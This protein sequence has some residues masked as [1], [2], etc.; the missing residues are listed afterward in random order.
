[1]TSFTTS[2]VRALVAD[3]RSEKGRDPPQQHFE[4]KEENFGEGQTM[5][6]STELPHSA[7]RMASNFTVIFDNFFVCMCACEFLLSRFFHSSP[8]PPR[9]SPPPR[10]GPPAALEFLGS[11]TPFRPTPLPP[12]LFKFGPSACLLP[13]PLPP[14]LPVS[15]AAFAPPVAARTARRNWRSASQMKLEMRVRDRPLACRHHRSC[16]FD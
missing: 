4:P 16:Y 8:A 14:R 1:M 3:I 6:A 5:K 2:A 10:P 11:G 15:A 12:P 13:P 9:V 7:A